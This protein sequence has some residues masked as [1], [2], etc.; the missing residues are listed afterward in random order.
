MSVQLGLLDDDRPKVFGSDEPAVVIRPSRRARRLILKVVPP[1]QI[2]LVVPRGTRPA[3]VEAFLSSSR[4]WIQ[5]ARA[6]LEARYP[7]ERRK[8]PTCIELE[9]IDARWDVDVV[10]DDRARAGLTVGAERLELRVPNHDPAAGF[11]ALR[12]WLLGQGRAHLRP[13]L[14]AEAESIGVMPSRVQIRTQRTR[15]GSCSQHGNISLNAALLLLPK[16]LVR[17]LLVHELCHLRHLDHSSR[18]WRFVAEHDPD[19]REHDAALAAAWTEIPI[20]ALPS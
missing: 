19:Y 7:N 3:D 16:V 1:F 6:E 18:Y 10:T 15:W 4:D 14:A 9:A 2:E 8:L 5:R 11:E 17:Y 13:W 12:Q 20:W